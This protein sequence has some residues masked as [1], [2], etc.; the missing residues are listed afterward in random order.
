MSF[1]PLISH[2]YPNETLIYHGYLGCSPLYP[3]V[4]ISIRT[5]ATYRQYH[6]TCP[7]FSIQA[8]C[9]ALCHLHNVGLLMCHNLYAYDVYLEIL[10]HVDRRLN[11]V[12]K[13]NTPNWRILNACPCCS[14]KLDEEAPQVIDRLFSINGNNSLKRWASLTYGLTPRVDPRQARSDYWVDRVTVDKFKDTVRRS[15]DDWEDQVAKPV[16]PELTFN[17]TERWRNAGPEQRKKMFAVFD[18]SGIFVATCWHRFVLLMCDMVRSGEL[19]KYPL[20]LM[21][22]LLSVF[23]ANASCAY[24]IGCAFSKT[25]GNSSLG[26]LAQSLNLRMMVGAFHG[27]AHNRRCQLDWHPMY[28]EGTGLTEGEGCEHVFSSS[29]ELAQGTRHTSRFH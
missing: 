21:S 17:C 4:A 12:R 1:Q 18:E 8:Q 15:E 27:H 23:G 26:P 7:Q 22:Q 3:S 20:A 16:E 6:Q 28:I 5:L 10:H 9:K 14:Y 11:E 29:N 25:L 19:A 24:D 2:R 13:C